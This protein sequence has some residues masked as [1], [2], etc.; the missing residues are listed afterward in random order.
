MRDTFHP[1]WIRSE[2]ALTVAV[3]AA[4]LACLISL[5]TIC[6]HLV[7]YNAPRMQL[8]TVRVL[9]IVPMYA[10]SSCLAMAFPSTG[11]YTEIARDVYEAFVIYSF[12]VLVL[13]CCGGEYQCILRLRHEPMLRHPW[14]LCKYGAFCDAGVV[15]GADHKHDN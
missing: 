1:E 6:L 14:P 11:I 4:V 15:S 8:Q 7:H 9:F 5:R 12:L 2:V 3:L 10:V 13:E